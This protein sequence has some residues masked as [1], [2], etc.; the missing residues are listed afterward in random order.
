MSDIAQH[1]G[2]TFRPDGHRV[3]RVQMIVPTVFIGLLS[4]ALPLLTLQVYDRILPNPESGT[5]PVLVAGVCVAVALEV[6]LR[7]ARAYS[8]GWSGAAYEHRMACQAMDHI[9]RADLGALAKSGS[10]EQLNRM[11]AIAK[12]RDFNNGYSLVTCAELGFV[13]LYL[14]L[15]YY[16]AGPL[17]LVPLAVLAVFVAG[18]V[19]TGRWLSGALARREEADDRRYDFLIESLKGIHTIKAFS[20]EKP[21]LRRYERRQYDATTA[22]YDVTDASSF[23][24]NAGTVLGHVMLA[25]VIACGA[26][27]VLAGQMT[28]GGLIAS[29][30]L[31]GRVMQPVQRAIGLWYRYQDYQTA[32]ERVRTLAAIP[33]V[34]YGAGVGVSD[35]PRSGLLQLEDVGAG[36]LFDH[37]DLNLRRGESVQLSGAYGC[38][39]TTL[40]KIMAG[41]YVPERGSVLVDGAAPDQIDPQRRMYHIGYIPTEGVAFRGRIRDNLTRF[42]LMQEEDIRPVTAMLGIDADVARLPRGFDTWMEGAEMDTIPPGLRQRIAVAR[43]LAA[44]PR[45]ILFDNADRNLDRD[46]YRQVHGLLGRLRDRVALVLVTDDLN[47]SRLAERRVMLTPEGLRDVPLVDESLLF[48]GEVRA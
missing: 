43:V 33:P 28:S 31:S 6:G 45:I 13:V 46:G 9:L 24:F 48:T 26:W 16:I 35:P 20:L 2:F 39:K 23:I 41:L 42:G 17:V 44:R 27:L 22:N 10:G 25:G 37:V 7:L 8:M 4:L 40:L 36:G 3:D 19:L 12:L 21:F 18:S 29:I 11:A 1:T 30:L 38:G 34:R 47:M 15:V 14:G 32:K 5:L